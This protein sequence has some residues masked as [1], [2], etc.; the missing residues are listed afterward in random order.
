MILCILI[1]ASYEDID[2]LVRP[3]LQIENYQGPIRRATYDADATV[4]P[5][6]S[7][8]GASPRFLYAAY[9]AILAGMSV[10][11][12]T[13]RGADKAVNPLLRPLA[14]ESLRAVGSVEPVRWHGLSN[15]GQIY[16][17][18]EH[19]MKYEWV[20]PQEVIKEVAAHLQDEGIDHW[21]QDKGRDYICLAGG[22]GVGNNRDN[23][24]GVYGRRRDIGLPLAGDN[25]EVNEAYSP[26]KP[27]VIVANDLTITQFNELMEFSEAFAD[28]G[29]VSLKYGEEDGRFKVFILPKEANKQHALQVISELT[30]IAVANT[31]VTGDSDNDAVMLN[32]AVAAGGA[33]MAVD[34][35][36]PATKAEASH[37]LPAQEDDGAAIGL[38][39]INRNLSSS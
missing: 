12:Q 15:G 2:E 37:L 17:L 13:A 30:R 29:V 34:N 10:G 24:L 33:G 32:A 14:T 27:L 21:V 4:V 18:L 22:V 11:Y 23:G 8:E 28:H 9:E 6:G 39:Y 25:L 31:A 7:L 26:E 16:D 20:I 36:A 19:K 5:D 3:G 35:A 38:S 1:M